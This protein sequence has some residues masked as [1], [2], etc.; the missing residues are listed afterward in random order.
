MSTLKQI[1]QHTDLAIGTVSEVLRGLPGY[2]ETTRKK[3]LLAA[4]QLN[5]RPNHLARGLRRKRSG[6]VGMVFKSLE[7]YPTTMSKLAVIEQQLRQKG[8]GVMIAN[9]YDDPALELEAIRQLLSSQVEG[10]ILWSS[11]NAN[12]KSLEGYLEDGLKLVTIE[13]PFSMATADVSVDRLAGGRMQVRHI[14]G[15]CRRRR[16]AFVSKQVGHGSGVKKI[17]GYEKGLADFGQCMDDHLFMAVPETPT[18]PFEAATLIA[19]QLI[20]RRG[21]FDAVVASSDIYGMVILTQLL[22]AGIAIPD[23]VAVIGFDDEPFSAHL[24]VSL[25]TIRQPLDVGMRVVD[26]LVALIQAKTVTAQMN[27]QEWCQPELM[28][29]QSTSTATSASPAVLS[30]CSEDH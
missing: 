11:T 1:S 3:V 15:D 29:R 24:P 22:N 17:Y 7:A 27:R 18:N 26:R 9:H 30:S 23:E 19:K 10:L 14:L 25:S 2:N 21:T 12:E 20:A 4:E 13:S 8:Y 28:V 5:Y 6:M 16:I